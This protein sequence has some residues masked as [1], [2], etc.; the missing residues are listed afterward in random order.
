MIKTLKL[1]F[2]LCAVS[3]FVLTTKMIQAAT[4]STGAVDVTNIRIA[5]PDRW[6]GCKARLSIDLQALGLDCLA[7]SANQLSWVTFSCSGVYTTK[8]NAYAMLN[9]AETSMFLKTPVNVAVD[10]TRKHDGVCFAYI[11][12]AFPPP[13]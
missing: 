11:I 12:V 8:D 5:T 7:D 2:M 3:S 10:D 13:D 9:V 6:G 4:A 1:A